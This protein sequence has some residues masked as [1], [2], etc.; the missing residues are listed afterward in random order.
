MNQRKNIFCAT[1]HVIR[2]KDE[3]AEKQ[4]ELI[5]IADDILNCKRFYKNPSHCAILGCPY[6]SICLS[7]TPETGAVDFIKKDKRNE[8][9]EGG[10]TDE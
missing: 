8:E 4:E 3:L 2:S 6:S 9:L 1:F 10:E 7:Y 5:Y